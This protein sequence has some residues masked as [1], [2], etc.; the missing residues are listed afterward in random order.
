[1]KQSLRAAYDAMGFRLA[2]EA[3]RAHDELALGADGIPER[4]HLAELLREGR[5]KDFLSVRDR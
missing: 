3:H 1:M 2:Q 4:D 5:L